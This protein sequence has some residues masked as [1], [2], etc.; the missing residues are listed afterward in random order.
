M[1]T[2]VELSSK[3]GQLARAMAARA[4][5]T[6]HP[7]MFLGLVSGFD[8]A[9]TLVEESTGARFGGLSSES[10][11]KM[12]EYFRDEADRSEAMDLQS[13]IFYRA[14]AE[15]IESEYSSR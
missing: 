10:A 12:V 4:G 3:A 15:V 8:V 2:I 5:L 11:T 6:P 13:A 9:I 7:T 14:W 1:P